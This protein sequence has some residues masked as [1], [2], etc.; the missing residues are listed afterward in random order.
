MK[1]ETITQTQESRPS[2]VASTGTWGLHSVATVLLAKAKS[3]A[4]KGKEFNAF[5]LS[6]QKPPVNIAD[7]KNAKSDFDKFIEGLNSQTFDG[8]EPTRFQVALLDGGHWTAFDIQIHHGKAKIF[9]IDAADDGR[10]QA[11]LKKMIDGLINFDTQSYR[12]LPD[13]RNGK[14]E[15][16][17]KDNV[18]CS[19]M[20]IQHLVETSKIDIFSKLETNEKNMKMQSIKD[21]GCYNLSAKDEYS[22]FNAEKKSEHVL[23][24]NLAMLASFSPGITALTQSFTTLE[25]LEDKGSFNRAR[26]VSVSHSS[27]LNHMVDHKKQ[28]Q[29][30]RSDN[31]L[32]SLPRETRDAAIKDFQSRWSTFAKCKDEQDRKVFWDDQKEAISSLTVDDKTTYTIVL[33][34]II[35][36]EKNHI[37]KLKISIAETRANNPTI[38]SLKQNKLSFISEFGR[39]E[40]DTAKK[41]LRYNKSVLPE[42]AN[43]LIDREINLNNLLPLLKKVESMNPDEFSEFQKRVENYFV[44]ARAETIESVKAII[45][46]DARPD[47]FSRNSISTSIGSN[48]SASISE[49]E[50]FKADDSPRSSISFRN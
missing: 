21:L 45:S 19:R 35:E 44:G 37:N 6:T 49:S 46:P 43:A 48:R 15:T 39:G 22:L 5:V 28:Q 4:L 32:G 8:S 41:C 29:I 7:A 30:T 25:S 42:K 34:H 18:N 12:F 16:I 1:S 40:Y 9:A 36:K 27:K 10:H 38:E 33:Q 14:Q 50:E 26:H 2:L 24:V 23:G 20:T 47:L 17:Q 31:L 3:R 13:E 11:S